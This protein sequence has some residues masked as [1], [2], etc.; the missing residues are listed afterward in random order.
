[1]SEELKPDCGCFCTDE[2]DDVENEYNHVRK[3]D[4]CQFPYWHEVAIK[5]GAEYDLLKK[6]RDALQKRV[7]ELEEICEGFHCSQCGQPFKTSACGPT[8]A[9]IASKLIQT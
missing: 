9:L 4:N 1:M 6:E 3:R 5:L 7:A 2:L 8:H